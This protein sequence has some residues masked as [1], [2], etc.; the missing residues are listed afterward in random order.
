MN[1]SESEKWHTHRQP[2]RKCYPVS[3]SDETSDESRNDESEVRHF[4]ESDDDD[5][6]DSEYELYE[7]GTMK[8][9]SMDS[10][11][12]SLKYILSLPELCDVKFQVG[13]M[14]VPVYG[15]KAI[16]TTRSR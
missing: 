16:L 11:S 12:E 10:L 15:V 4:S 9:T 7:G 13:P 1:D 6:T 3:E 2:N 5:D 8:F 14:K